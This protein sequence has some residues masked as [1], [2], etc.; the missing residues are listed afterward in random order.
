MPFDKLSER[1]A[2]SWS[3]CGRCR[4]SR[5][6]PIARTTRP[7]AD[8]AAPPTVRGSN[9]TSVVTCT[10][11][12]TDQVGGMNAGTMFITKATSQASGRASHPDI[13]SR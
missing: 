4:P 9:G 10:T 1:A 3:V 6:L 5:R 8:A 13:R 11:A 12:R 7:A 2:F